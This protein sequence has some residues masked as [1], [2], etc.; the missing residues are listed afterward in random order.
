MQTP[1]HSL[2]YSQ[3]CENN[4][5]VIAQHLSRLLQPVSYAPNAEQKTDITTVLEI[6]S[7]TGQHAVHFGQALPHI[8]WQTSDQAHYHAGIKLW[9]E[10]YPSTNVRAPLTLNV[11]TNRWPKA[12]AA[13]SANT[14]HIMP[15]NAVEAMFTGVGHML[16]LA[17][18]KNS[19]QHNSTKPG[20]S[21]S[22]GNSASEVNSAPDG[23]T[24]QG[25][26]VLYGPF[27]YNGEFTSASNARFDEH[28]RASDPRQGIRDF[29]AICQLAHKAGLHI[30]EDNPMPA[31]NQLLVFK[32]VGLQQ[33]S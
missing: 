7:G 10:A 13:Y 4:K 27:K 23:N 21:A 12:N 32:A 26:F 6:G 24:A 20:S 5:T 9:L 30:L 11:L 33:H 25:L 14:A 8:I 15:W 19:A 1:Q 22:D 29:E 17:H 28:L 16:N 18:S 2:P 3:A 31:N